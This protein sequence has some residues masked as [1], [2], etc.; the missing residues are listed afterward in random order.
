M[1]S[2]YSSANLALFS[3]EYS[4]ALPFKHV[5]IDGFLENLFVEELLA[6]FPSVSDPSILVNEFGV[7]NPKSCISDLKGLGGVYKEFDR[8]IQGDGF[9]KYI[10]KVT[11]IPDIKYDP[12][13][14]GAGTHEN[15]HGAGLDP[16]YDFNIHPATGQH[17]RL[18]AI[19]YLNKDWNPEWGGS[20]CLH[21]DAWNLADS[22]VVEIGP[23]FNRM[24]LFETTEKSWHS[25]P[26]IRQP[27]EARNF[28][29]KSL[30]IY[31]YTDA[32]P[33]EELASPHG[34][35]YVQPALSRH[36]KAGHTLTDADFDEINSNIVRRQSYLKELYR[37]EYKFSEIIENLRRQIVDLERCIHVPMVGYVRISKVYKGTYSDSWI[38]DKLS[39][40]IIPVL[41]I[42]GVKMHGFRHLSW[43][44]VGCTLRVGDAALTLEVAGEN[45]CVD[46]KFPTPVHDPIGL[47][48][49]VDETRRAS[50]QDARLVSIL[51]VTLEMIRR[52]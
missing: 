28:S 31:L 12:Y 2:S 41:P 36:I 17:R 23:A 15:F 29:R 34:T 40:Q 24:V 38:H 8:F 3:D 50:E 47:D 39:F 49:L 11:G 37:R 25:V 22:E 14:Y 6:A 51:L 7:R 43:G 9:L 44:A 27:D 13:Y 45:I 33:T 19:I 16:H 42:T 46:L 35:V 20:L 32:R 1:L 26:T 52:V 21:R 5:V 48:F 30:T 4:N 18:N 10:E